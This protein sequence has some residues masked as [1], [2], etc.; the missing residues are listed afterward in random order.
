MDYLW[1]KALHIIAV[2]TWVSG[3]MIVAVTI[4]AAGAGQRASADLSALLGRVRL[5]DR[6]VTTPAMLLVWGL[7]LTLA[8][9]GHWFEQ[10]WLSI[11]LA[12]VLLLSALHGMLSG[13]LRRL[14]RS[15]G[16]GAA[17]T[18]RWAAPAIL[19]AVGVV[20]VLVVVKP[21]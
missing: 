3:M 16:A 5:W 15:D 17:P 8:L 14:T 1:L 4:A 21:F 18:I 13:T 7:G 10:P 6:R 11:K 12:V 2:V 9:M 20:V 19:L